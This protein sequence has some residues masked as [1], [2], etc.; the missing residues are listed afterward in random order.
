MTDIILIIFSIIISALGIINL[1][2][3]IHEPNLYWWRQNIK[4]ARD[5][6]NVST[7]TQDEVE[8]SEHSA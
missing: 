8:D 6:V 7:P 4:E 2:T 3:T 5:S 1:I